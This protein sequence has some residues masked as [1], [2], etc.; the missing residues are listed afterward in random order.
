ML[1]TSAVHEDPLPSRRKNAALRMRW[2][3]T[4]GE[5]VAAPGHW[6]IR[7]VF[8]AVVWRSAAELYYRKSLFFI[9]P[10]TTSRMYLKVQLR[11][12]L[13]LGNFPEQYVAVERVG[14]T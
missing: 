4:S 1:R 12:F 10:C 7:L 11:H 5:E 3:Y 14:F 13:A 6:Y 9:S 2:P 8:G